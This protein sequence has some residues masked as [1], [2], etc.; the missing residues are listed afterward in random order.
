MALLILP[1]SH[2]L[3]DP[4]GSTHRS[5]HL[6]AESHPQ[7]GKSPAVNPL[8]LVTPHPCIRGAC[9]QGVSGGTSSTPRRA[10][11]CHARER[12]FPTLCQVFKLALFSLTRMVCVSFME[13]GFWWPFLAEREEAATRHHDAVHSGRCSDHSVSSLGGVLTLP[14]IGPVAP[15]LD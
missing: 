3:E 15:N 10:S 6:A 11:N 2:S 1:F 8:Q 4:V 12:F 5:G 13:H 7:G 14:P 9:S